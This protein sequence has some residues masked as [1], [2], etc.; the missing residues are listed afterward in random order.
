MI[1]RQFVQKVALILDKLLLVPLLVQKI[2]Q[3]MD[4]LSPMNN[5]SRKWLGFWT[6]LMG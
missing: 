5:L 3:I 6:N 4:K 2:A 1:L